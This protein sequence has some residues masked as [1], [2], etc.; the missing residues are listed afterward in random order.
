MRK[1]IPNKLFES[2]SK[3]SAEYI[4][5]IKKLPILKL[6]SKNEPDVLEGA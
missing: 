2:L 1:I 3:D 6:W 5:V 4:L